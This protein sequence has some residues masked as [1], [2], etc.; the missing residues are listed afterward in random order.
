MIHFGV[1][2]FTFAVTKDK[3]KSTMNHLNDT[4]TQAEQNAQVLH[5]N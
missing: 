4:V 2:D 3:K 1:F 5:L